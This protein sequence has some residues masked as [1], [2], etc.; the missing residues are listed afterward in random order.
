M[1]FQDLG[2]IGELIAAIATVGTLAYLAI[3]IRH[4]SRTSAA[5]AELECLKL[6]TDWVGRISANSES[7][8]L[9]DLAADNAQMSAVESRQYLW[10]IGEFGWICQTAFIQYKRGHLSEIAWTEFQRMQI[11]IL[12]SDLAKEW[13]SNRETPYSN[14]FVEFIDSVQHEGTAW[15]PK[16]TARDPL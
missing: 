8:R 10:L 7:Q 16:V 2:S 1:N 9:Y 13:W 5:S 3:Q 15:R 4:N 6:L 14:E 11:G 12:Q